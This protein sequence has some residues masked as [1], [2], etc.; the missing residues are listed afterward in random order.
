MVRAPVAGVVPS[1]RCV[2]YVV[3]GTVGGLAG[4]AAAQGAYSMLLFYD[5]PADRHHPYCKLC[6]FELHRAGARYFSAGRSLVD[7]NRSAELATGN[8]RDSAAAPANSVAHKL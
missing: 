4:F 3:C 1:I 6:F 2:H 8:T 5:L 7:S